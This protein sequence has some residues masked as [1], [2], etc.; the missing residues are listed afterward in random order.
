MAEHADRSAR[1]IPSLDPAPKIL[2]VAAPYYQRVTAQLVAGAEAVLGPA[3]AKVERL[4]VAG[5]LEIAASIRLAH[6]SG[7]FDGFVAL[8]C[9]IRGATS[10]YDIVCNETSRGLTLLGVDRGVCI[11]NGVLTVENDAQA[12]ERADPAR[13]DK[14]G[15]AAVAC[16]M[17]IETARR[18][19]GGGSSFRPDDEHM[20]LA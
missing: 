5:A 16:L 7:R 4:D 19:G 15:D 14:G 2:I 10:H 9:V 17:L 6:E 8:G 1:K 3:G 20:L 13:L 18:F 12:D 11:G